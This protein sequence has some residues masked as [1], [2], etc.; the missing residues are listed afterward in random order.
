VVKLGTVSTLAIDTDSMRP[1]RSV[2]EIRSV[3]QLRAL[4]SPMRHRIVAAFEALGRCTVREL[5][6]HLD[7]PAESLY[8]HLRVLTRAG[9]VVEAGTKP[10]ERRLA[11]LYELIS[12]DLEVRIE[13]ASR[14]FREAYG[15]M[16]SALLRWADRA[17]RAALHD[18]RAS[19]CGE[20]R[21]RT[22]VQFHPRLGPDAIVELNRRLD[23]IEAFLLE[24]EDPE[25]IPYV[26]TMV[27]SPA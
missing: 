14:E 16:G 13:G 10:T 15:R 25:G 17:H 21:Q 18:A 20:G 12:R 24:S 26:V 1:G 2:L 19:Q 9:L 6:D 27:V 23:A 3:Q 8:Y 7:V 22:M 5:A 11:Q 4:A